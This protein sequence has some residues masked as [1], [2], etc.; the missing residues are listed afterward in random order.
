MLRSLMEGPVPIGSLGMV[1]N[2][3]TETLGRMTYEY[4][5]DYLII[6]WGPVC[7]IIPSLWLL[8][9]TNPL[10]ACLPSYFVIQSEG[11]D[12]HLA[13]ILLTYVFALHLGLNT[14]YLVAGWNFVHLGGMVGCVFHAL[15]ASKI[16]RRVSLIIAIFMTSAVF[17]V[18]GIWSSNVSTRILSLSERSFVT[19]HNMGSRK[20]R[21]FLDPNFGKGLTNEFGFESAFSVDFNH[22]ILLLLALGFAM[23]TTA[24]TQTILLDL[25]STEMESR[26]AVLVH[27]ALI[28]WWIGPKIGWITAA[29]FFIHFDIK[30]ALIA[31]VVIH[32]VLDLIFVIISLESKGWERSVQ[33]SGCP[34]YPK[35]LYYAIYLWPQGALH[36]PDMVVYMV[37][38]RQHPYSSVLG[39]LPNRATSSR[40]FGFFVSCQFWRMMYLPTIAIMTLY[41]L[42]TPNPL[43]TSLFM[44]FF[45]MYRVLE[46]F[47]AYYFFIGVYPAF[48][49]QY[50]EISSVCFFLGVCETMRFLGD[51]LAINRWPNM[52]YC[53]DP[54]NCWRSQYLYSHAIFQTC[55]GDGG[56]ISYVCW[57]LFS[58]SQKRQCCCPY[59]K[60]KQD[61]PE[62]CCPP[63]CMGPFVEDSGGCPCPC[64]CASCST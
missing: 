50:I 33:V 17:I 15:T 30:G 23:S 35:A 3:M 42:S 59:R 47:D 19:D 40:M 44:E 6:K 26:H 63:C 31:V 7:T 27:G 25:W 18:F 8:P 4:F 20:I 61:A 11:A 48:V 58:K 55:G 51:F 62:K 22:S 29:L 43:N 28:Y 57:Y 54:M 16:T 60:L 52:L 5:W 64:C 34:C 24:V 37:Y 38:N 2:A 36:I 12:Y 46:G 32:K 49:A 14:T 53:G 41:A 45:N 9:R 13:R 39:Q 21:P 1:E 10:R 56:N